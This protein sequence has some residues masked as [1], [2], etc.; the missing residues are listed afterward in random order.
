M[1]LSLFV[2]LILMTCA[3]EKVILEKG[4]INCN[5]PLEMMTKKGDQF[6]TK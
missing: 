6:F 5:H 3:L 1:T 4:I 2:K